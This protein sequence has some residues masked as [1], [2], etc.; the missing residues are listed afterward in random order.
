MT[1]SQQ[2]AQY[3][4]DI[5]VREL[6]KDI[7]KYHRWKLTY[8]GTV[9]TI[10]SGADSTYLQVMVS[11]GPSILDYKVIQLTYDESVNM[12][13]IYEESKVVVWGYPL[14]M[15]PFIN[16]NGAKID[17]PLLGGDFIEMQ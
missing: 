14:G 13:G 16:R 8:V 7:T 10:Y 17:Q 11:Y 12:D 6:Y 1:V 4:G 5:D 15:L 2:K 9:L 3:R